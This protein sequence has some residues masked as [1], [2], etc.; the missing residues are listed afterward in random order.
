M[1]ESE[2]MSYP[3]PLPEEKQLAPRVRRFGR[4]GPIVAWIV[5]ALATVFAV[6]TRESQPA[7]APQAGDS[8]LVRELFEFQAKSLVGAGALLGDQGTDSIRQP[9]EQWRPANSGEKLRQAIVAGELLGF[10]EALSR[11]KEPLPKQDADRDE[12]PGEDA[13]PNAEADDAEAEPNDAPEAAAGAA[14]DTAI[15]DILTRLY[16]DYSRD[17]LNAPSVTDAE[18]ERLLSELGWFGALA[19]APPGQAS[20]LRDETIGA[21][22]RAAS[23]SLL[24][25]GA[26]LAVALA[27]LTLLIVFAVLL[28]K[29]RLSSFDATPG[30]GAVYVE[31]FAVWLLLFLILSILGAVWP[32]PQSAVLATLIAMGGSLSAL[33]WPALRGVPWREVC[34]DLGWTR[35]RGLAIEL[36]A[37]LGGYAMAVALLV[38]ALM[39]MTPLLS[40]VAN[41]AEPGGIR[42]HPAAEWVVDADWWRLAPL[43]LLACVM[44]PIL[45]ETV[46]RGL[47]YRHLREATG[48]LPA[49]GS[50]LFSA[51][52]T[53]ALFAILHPQDLLAVP[54]IMGIALALAFMRE[55]RNTLLPSMIGHAVSN[56]V[57]LLALTTVVS[58]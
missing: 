54:F 20:E 3:Q 38:A 43:F 41:G 48:G 53:G 30:N 58:A 35:G 32:G 34:A 2:A 55:W 7:P 23:L 45:E 12:K 24:A 13:E 15:Q 39:V 36:L 22:Q 8:P 33:A 26:G 49:W 31:T 5:I 10:D 50:V 4:G 27:G 51:V 42:A 28:L 46:F 14:D 56:A 21:A 40:G 52:V 25:M 1:L 19:L 57:T 9:L 6:W 16:E 17:E 47:L 44:A 18:R 37:G 11:L 29:G